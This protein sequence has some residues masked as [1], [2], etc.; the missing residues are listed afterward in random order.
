MNS[1]ATAFRL[2]KQYYF[3]IEESRNREDI[4]YTQPELGK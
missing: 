2:K 1:E 3:D 4:K